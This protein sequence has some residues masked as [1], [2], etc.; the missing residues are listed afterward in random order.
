MIEFGQFSG[1][2]GILPFSS[3]WGYPNEILH[4]IQNKIAWEAPDLK[5]GNIVTMT[6]LTPHRS[7]ILS[8]FPRVALNVKIQPSNICYLEN[9]YGYSLKGISKL[10]SL[11]DQICYIRDILILLSRKQRLVL[12]ELAVTYFLLGEK[13]NAMKSLRELCLFKVDDQILE[14]WLLASILRKHIKNITKKDLPKALNPIENVVKLSCGD[15]I[16][17]TI[18][19]NL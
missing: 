18:S 10:N 17:E 14:S 16:L 12:F 3:E 6:A 15:A 8:Q 11:K 7:G 9:T 19:L 4:D 5:P 13:K 2:I 1:K